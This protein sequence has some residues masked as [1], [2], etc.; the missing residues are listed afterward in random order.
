MGPRRT[1]L[2]RKEAVLKV[3][4][5]VPEMKKKSRKVPLEEGKKSAPAMCERNLTCELKT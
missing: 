2:R 3:S 5:P 4:A 1:K